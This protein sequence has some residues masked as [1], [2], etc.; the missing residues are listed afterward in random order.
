MSK[1]GKLLL[2]AAVFFFALLVVWAVRTV[3]EPPPIIKD[4]T[5]KVMTYDQNT[6]SEEK[7]GKKIWE[8]TAESTTV[9]VDN[10]DIL[11]NVLT[12]HFYAEDGRIVTIT[13]DKGAYSHGSRDIWVTGNVKVTTSDG[14]ELTAD[15][16]HWSAKEEKLTAKGNAKATKED[17]KLTADEIES[18]DGFNI[19]KAKGKAHIEKG[20][21]QNEN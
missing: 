4:D 12:G 11:M 13:A 15:E 19:V 20:K 21:A 9:N 17:M 18:T 1:K 5:P 6:I 3:P 14:A 8:L 16:F 2:A 7:A 10:E